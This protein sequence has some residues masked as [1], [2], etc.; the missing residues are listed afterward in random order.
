LKQKQ[1][2]AIINGLKEWTFHASFFAVSHAATK[3]DKKVTQPGSA[4]SSLFLLSAGVH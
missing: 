1:W 4:I 2:L 3:R